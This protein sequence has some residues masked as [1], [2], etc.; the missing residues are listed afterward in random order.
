MTL[1]A[2][3]E[4]VELLTQELLEE[5]VNLFVF[6]IDYQI[7]GMEFALNY[8]LNEGT[9]KIGNEL[10]VEKIINDEGKTCKYIFE[11]NKIGNDTENVGMTYIR[12]EVA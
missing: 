6:D 8:L 5:T 10:T 4:N 11:V 9:Y 7:L 3:I 2:K 1:Q 12:K